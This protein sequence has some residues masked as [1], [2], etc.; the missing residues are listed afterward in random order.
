MPSFCLRQLLLLAWVLVA[1]VSTSTADVFVAEELCQT[2][3]TVQYQD[4]VDE[5]MLGPI[6]LGHGQNGATI[7]LHPGTFI[8]TAEVRI[9]TTAGQPEASVAYRGVTQVIDLRS[10]LNRPTSIVIHAI[11]IRGYAADEAVDYDVPPVIMSIE[12]SPRTIDIGGEATRITV[13]ARDFN[14]PMPADYSPDMDI[15][16]VISRMSMK[17]FDVDTGYELA[18]PDDFSVGLFGGVPGLNGYPDPVKIGAFTWAASEAMFDGSLLPV[19]RL[20]AEITATDSSGLSDFGVVAFTV[21][22]NQNK[23]IGAYTFR[24]PRINDVVVANQTYRTEHEGPNSIPAEIR[25]SVYDSDHETAANYT[26]DIFVA[27]ED[28]TASTMGYADQSHT[29]PSSSCNHTHGLASCEYVACECTPITID[30]VGS[31]CVELTVT[32]PDDIDGTWSFQWNPWQNITAASGRYGTTYCQLNLHFYD[33]TASLNGSMQ[34]VPDG[35]RTRT[36]TFLLV[37][38]PGTPAIADVDH[39]PSLT[40]FWAAHTEVTLGEVS[41]VYRSPIPPHSYITVNYEDTDDSATAPTAV[42]VLGDGTPASLV[43]GPDLQCEGSRCTGRWTVD[44]SQLSTGSP[45]DIYLQLTDNVT[46]RVGVHKVATITVT[47]ADR[48]LRRARSGT[49]TGTQRTARSAL[50]TT[51]ITLQIFNGTLSGST[52]GQIRNGLGGG[53]TTSPQITDVRPDGEATAQ[54]TSTIIIATVAGF[55]L[56]LLGII[57]GIHCRCQVQPKD[58]KP[59]SMPMPTSMSQLSA[60]DSAHLWP[61]A[62]TNHYWPAGPSSAPRLDGP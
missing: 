51:I 47:P 18:G 42:L 29:I 4:V 61:A 48:R 44:A 2:S 12:I 9:C 5:P 17:V 14:H 34:S 38:S 24:A 60:A 53:S 52:N 39:P 7:S 37:A 10:S 23:A 35:L 21:N 22:H 1:R 41:A 58:P 26:E 49:A 33:N 50:A 6:L 40:S 27:I 13:S 55:A 3:I 62:G 25:L 43:G 57:A 20:R 8:A 59:T 46:E 15:D 31:S 54:S 28:L 32:K 56:L 30:G 19:H 36:A 45:V 16:G 11:D